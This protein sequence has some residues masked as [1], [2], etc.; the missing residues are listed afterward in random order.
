MTDSESLE[1]N[2]WYG[3]REWLV[4]CGI[5]FILM[6]A[7]LWLANHGAGDM[8]SFG[9]VFHANANGLL[10]SSLMHVIVSYNVLGFATGNFLAMIPMKGLKYELKYA[11]VSCLSMI[12]VQSAVL[13][14]G[15][16]L[17]SR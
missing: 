11:K 13:I 8:L 12:A 2:P 5:L 14:Y 17:I 15:L 10:L 9:G 7:N 6:G 1:S 3:R 16:F 4:H